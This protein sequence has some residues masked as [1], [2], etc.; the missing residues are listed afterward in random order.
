MRNCQYCCPRV[1]LPQLARVI[2]GMICGV[3][4]A[5][6]IDLLRPTLCSPSAFLLLPEMAYKHLEPMSAPL[7]DAIESNVYCCI[8]T[9]AITAAEAKKREWGMS[10]I[11]TAEGKTTL[12]TEVTFDGI[13]PRSEEKPAGGLF[14]TGGKRPVSR[15]L[16]PVI[17]FSHYWEPPN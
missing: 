14:I 1:P 13:D 15:C 16:C 6:C 9:Q 4:I 8:R 5:G 11:H 7:G 10:S 17:H 12:Q 3:L 2:C